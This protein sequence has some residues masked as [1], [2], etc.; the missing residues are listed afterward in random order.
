MQTGVGYINTDGQIQSGYTATV[1]TDFDIKDASQPVV[2]E[3]DLYP[4]NLQVEFDPAN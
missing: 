2:L 1:T 3:F 4:Q